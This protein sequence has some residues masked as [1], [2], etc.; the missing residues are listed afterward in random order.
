M[1][2]FLGVLGSAISIR[3]PGA[4]AVID[5][6]FQGSAGSTLR[7]VTAAG[8]HAAS[9]T[10]TQERI[11]Y[12][13]G[14]TA[15]LCV[16]RPYSKSGSGTPQP[17]EGAAI[18]ARFAEVGARVLDELHGSFA[19]AI[20]DSARSRG[21]V[22]TDRMGVQPVFFKLL[23]RALAFGSAPGDVVRVTGARP[24][25]S[26]QALFDYFYGH[27]IPAPHSIYE[28]VQRLLPGECIEVDGNGPVQ[29]TY[30]RARF[31]EN[32][33]T[34]FS[35]LKDQFLTS[36]RGS[37]EHAMQGARCGAFLS[38]G[39]DS[40]TVT[41][42]MAEIGGEAPKT[43]SIGFAV[44]G[45]DEM[46]YARL[47]S[48]HFRTRHHEYYVTPRDVVDALPRIAVSHP[49]PFGNSS[50]LP[51][52][53]CARLARENGVERLLA[54]DGGDEL[55]GGNARYA[56]Q[57]VFAA[58]ERVPES[59]RRR[60]I[61]PLCRALSARGRL[62]VVGKATSYVEQASVPMP[63]RLET[64]NALHRIGFGEV[65][66]AALLAAVDTAEPA[67]LNEAAFFNPTAESLINRMLAL[68]FKTTL[69]DSD[70]P[71]VMQS[72]D[73]AGVAVSFPMLDPRVVDF[74]LALAPEMKLKGTQLRYFFKRSLEGFLPEA[75]IRKQKHGF[76]LPF[77]AWAVQDAQLRALTLDTL[78]SFKRREL[79]RPAFVDRLIDTLLPEYPNYYGTLAWIFMSLEL[80]LR[81]HADTKQS[82]VFAHA[83]PA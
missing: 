47:A 28:G 17:V 59:L 45:Y 60:V 56:K 73:L 55:F 24:V 64:Y 42:L 25:L 49:Q 7:A 19:L 3:L 77:G 15:L 58:Y 4:G 43:F 57:R 6:L 10:E 20:F 13:A 8:F 40:S 18:A 31:V 39:T 78:S 5:E 46:E 44:S 81:S 35:T 76:G 82:M 62:P 61:E 11:A 38:G 41:G 2:R 72:C 66:D 16:G 63:A 29:R 48:T 22:A 65:L 33:D 68:D 34:D 69:A 53:L 50:A 51:T 75:I 12:A 23:D 36:L 67:R 74:S 79:V 14:T 1:S 54:G 21:L 9:A 80:W 30:W 70:L 52:Y 27:V 26:R 71:K 37:V 32:D 83:E